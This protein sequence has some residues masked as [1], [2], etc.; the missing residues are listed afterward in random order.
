[1]GIATQENEGPRAGGLGLLSGFVCEESEI[2]WEVTMHSTHSRTEKLCSPF[3]RAEYLLILKLLTIFS[4]VA[5]GLRH[6]L[7]IYHH[8]LQIVNSVP[9]IYTIFAPL[10]TPS[11]YYCHICLYMLKTNILTVVLPNFLSFG[12]TKRR[13]D[14]HIHTHIHKI[15][16]DI[17][18]IWHSSVFPMLSSYH[19][20]SLPL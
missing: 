7:L 20:M 19:Q 14:T 3:L 4:A 12:E 15:L 5:R 16:K 9:V 1:M 6:Y 2:P 17:Y 11:C 10:C 13:K 8:L 18:R